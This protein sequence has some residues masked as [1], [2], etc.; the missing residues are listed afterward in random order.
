MI[1]KCTSTEDV[2]VTVKTPEKRKEIVNEKSEP[3]VS[4]TVPDKMDIVTQKS[5]ES[6]L[7]Q[8]MIL[9]STRSSLLLEMENR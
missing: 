6:Q 3:A 5:L 9:A 4:A 2:T 8:A 1:D 7:K